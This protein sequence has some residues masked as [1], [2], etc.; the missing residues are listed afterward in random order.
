MLL[1]TCV[2]GDVDNSVME[3]RNNLPVIL[4]IIFVSQTYECIFLI[5]QNIPD[6]GRTFLPGLAQVPAPAGLS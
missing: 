2:N 5:N 1:D 4:S 6:V 3:R